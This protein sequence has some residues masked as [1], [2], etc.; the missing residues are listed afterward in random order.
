MMV[1][2]TDLIATKDIATLVGVRISAV[3]NW[4]QRHADFPQPLFELAG[5]EVPVYS[6]RAM[7]AWLYG[8]KRLTAEKFLELSSP[9]GAGAGRRRPSRAAP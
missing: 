5:G 7:L 6:R 9:T 3:S 4:R 2:T 1:D 8:T